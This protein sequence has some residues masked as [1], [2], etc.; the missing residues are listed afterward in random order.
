MMGARSV[1]VPPA[2]NGSAGDSPLARMV[3]DWEAEIACVI[4]KR[5]K[6]IHGSAHF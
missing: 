3:I 5:G 1:N 6:R 4:A 2:E